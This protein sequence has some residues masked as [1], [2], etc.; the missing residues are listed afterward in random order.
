MVKSFRGFRFDPELYAEFKELVARSNFTITEA[1]ERF[2]SACVSTGAV[3]FPESEE[4][5]RKAGRDAEAESRILLTWL[6]KG[7]F[8]YHVKGE[9]E[10]SV[11]GRLLQLLPRIRDENL[12]VEV[13]EELKKA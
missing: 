3:R 8:W 11:M 9:E 6:K 12:R 5:E 1:F 10:L 2:M 13:E 7:E 4:R